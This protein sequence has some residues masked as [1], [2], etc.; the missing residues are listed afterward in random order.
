[1]GED[2]DIR[3]PSCQGELGSEGAEG[4]VDGVVSDRGCGGEE[5]CEGSAGGDAAHGRRGG[6]RG[7][8]G[9]GCG[10]GQGLQFA[11]RR[12]VGLGGGSAVMAVVVFMSEGCGEGGLD[13]V[14]CGPI[15]GEGGWSR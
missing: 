15:Y 2:G 10:G 7:G 14:P 12:V 13:C 3:E 9:G 8:G 4:K 6:V 1:M 11:P 5:L